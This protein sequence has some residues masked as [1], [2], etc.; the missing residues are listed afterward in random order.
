MQET[1]RILHIS[2]TH[3]GLRQYGLIEREMDFYEVFREAINIAVEE[4]VDAVIH[5]GDF[6][7]TTRP[8][9]Q[10]I[11][12]AIDAARML[13]EKGIPLIAV[14]GDHD[15]PRRREMPPLILLEHIVDNVHVIGKPSSK[16]VEATTIRVRGGKKLFVAGFAGQR[17]LKA[18]ALPHLLAAAPRPPDDTVSILVLHQA[19][20][21]AGVPE[22]ELSIADLPRGYTYYAMG[23]IHDYVVLGDKANPIVY[24]GSPEYTRVDSIGKER[25]IV[26]A[27][28]AAKHA[29]GVE[30]VRLRKVR[31]QLVYRVRAG[32]VNEDIKAIASTLA[33]TSYS[34]RPLLHVVVEGSLSISERKRLRELLENTVSKLVL[35]Y[36]VRFETTRERGAEA[37]G[38]PD[39]QPRTLD[40]YELLRQRL[41]DEKLAEL[42]YRLIQALGYGGPSEAQ[43]EAIRVTYEWFREVFGDQP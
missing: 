15:V 27:E 33:R 14:M 26:L 10:A 9:M 8:P 40:L 28:L 21:E 31:P 42:A 16:G 6:F 22:Y 1:I 37:A 2:D 39:Q 4:R 35:D 36:R 38:F 29:V 32:T 34:K 41:K 17:G 12:E 30:K 20:R 19:V 5:S 43:R 25:V 3:L 18:K 11:R 23:H 13:R 24:P 7:D